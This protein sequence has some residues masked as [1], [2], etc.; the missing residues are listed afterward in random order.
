MRRTLQEGS[1]G[2]EVTPR[3]RSA[4][5]EVASSG[6]LRPGVVPRGKVCLQRTNVHACPR[7]FAGRFRLPVV[8]FGRSGSWQVSLFTSWMECI[9]VTA[10]RRHER[11]RLGEHMAGRATLPEPVVITGIGLLASTGLDRESVWQSVQG[12]AEQLR[13]LAGDSRESLMA[14]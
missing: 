10:G 8:D 11:L 7:T 12:R 13:P 9:R 3:V 2:G 4:S 6:G 14:S 5:R 1:G